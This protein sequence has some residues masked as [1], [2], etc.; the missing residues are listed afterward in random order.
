M[1]CIPK[2]IVPLVL[3]W[4]N[5]FCQERTYHR[6]LM[7]LA[8]AVLTVGTRTASNMLRTIGKLAYGDPSS[9]HRLFSMRRWTTRKL[10]Q[11]SIAFILEH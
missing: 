3:R 9:Y 11:I 5:T 8:A 6:F 2:K 1:E 7:L 4:R 10:S